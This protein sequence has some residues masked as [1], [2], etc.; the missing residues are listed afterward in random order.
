MLAPLKYGYGIPI[1][2]IIM[3]TYVKKYCFP[4]FWKTLRRQLRDIIDEFYKLIVSEQLDEV[5]YISY[6]LRRI[7][8]NEPEGPSY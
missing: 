4:R 2:V 7:N 8:K 3:E 6:K 5:V 1:F